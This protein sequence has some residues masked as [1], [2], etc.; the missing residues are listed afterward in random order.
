MKGFACIKLP[1]KPRP[2]TGVGGNATVLFRALLPR[3]LAGRLEM[4]SVTVVRE[5]LP[6]LLSAG[7]LEILGATIDL[8]AN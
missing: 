2:A 5:D 6:H 1:G 3:F 4:A 7:F 8:P